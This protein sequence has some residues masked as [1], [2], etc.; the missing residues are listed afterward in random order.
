MS[1]AAAA[2]HAHGVVGMTTS[3]TGTGS[4][5]RAST[6]G[7]GGAH[8]HGVVEMTTR[9]TGDLAPVAPAA[10]RAGAVRR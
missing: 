5:S 8:G 9:C 1:I 2:V 6:P 7:G 4:R 10:P 3:C